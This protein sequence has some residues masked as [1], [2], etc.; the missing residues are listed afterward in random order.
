[1]RVYRTFFNLKFLIFQTAFQGAT[2]NYFFCHKITSFHTSCPLFAYEA[3]AD[4]SRREP[5]DGRRGDGMLANDIERETCKEFSKRDEDGHVHCNECPLRVT[6]RS[7]VMCKANCHY[8]R[9]TGEWEF[10][11]R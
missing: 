8:N 10:D 6:G 2:I 1:M 4:G 5:V 7:E 9:S 11:Y 3:V